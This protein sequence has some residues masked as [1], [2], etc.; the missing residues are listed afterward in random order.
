MDDD[1]NAPQAIAVLFDLA[2][3]VNRALDAPSGLSP[4]ALRSVAETFDGLG[5]TVLG[6]IPPA[7]RSAGGDAKTEAGLIELLLRVRTEVRSAKLWPLSDLIR[8]GLK[9][10]GIIVEDRKDGTLWRRSL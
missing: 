9:A 10:L 2:S 6:I 4:D 5:G 3:E 7:S 8:D 1:F